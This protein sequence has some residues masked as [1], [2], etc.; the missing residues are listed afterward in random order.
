MRLVAHLVLIYLTT[1]ADFGV[2]NERLESPTLSVEFQPDTG[3]WALTDKRSGVRYPTVGFVATGSCAALDRP[4]V[5][6]ER[7]NANAVSVVHDEGVAVT[8]SLVRDGQS[9]ELRFE[10]NSLGEVRTLGDLLHMTKAD[11][12]SIVV[13]CREGLLI[14]VDEGNA[15]KRT[16]ASSD[17][18]GCHMNMIG[19]LK[20]GSAMLAT[21]DDA[22]T[23]PEVERS[24]D[25]SDSNSP[26]LTARFKLKRTARSIRLTPLGNG[27]WNTL[28]EGYRQI[29]EEKGMVVTLREKLRRNQG[30]ERM[31]GA[32]NVKLWHCLAR[33][34]NE[35]ST[36]EESVRVRWTF[37]ESAQIAEHIKKDLQIDRCLFIIG[38]FTEGGYDC[39]H[40]D[41]LPAN[42]ECGGNFALQ[43]AI[44]R[45]KRLGYVACLHDNYQDMYGNAKSFDLRYI[46]KDDAGKPKRG[47]R[48]L[49]GKP[50]LVCAPKQLELAMRPQNLPEIHRLF[51]PGNYFI[52]TTYAVGPRE[53]SDPNHPLDYNDDIRWKKKLSDHA[54][55]LFGLFGSEGGREWALPHSDWFEGLVGV[56]GRYFNDLKPRR[57][58]ARVIPFWEMVYHDCQIAYGKYGFRP[59]RAA[60]YV[61]HHALCARPLHYHSLPDHIYWKQNKRDSASN[62]E[63]SSL[64][65]E[66][67][68]TRT[69][70]GWAEGLHPVDAFLKNS[71]ELLGP[72]HEATAH[73]RLEHFEFLSPD[74]KLRRATYGSNE[75]KTTIV[76]NLGQEPANVTSHYGVDVLLPQ[77]GIVIDTPRFAAFYALRWNGQNYPGGALFT[78]RAADGE[79]LD[80]ASNVRVFH[81]FGPSR[82]KWHSRI[83]DVKKETTIHK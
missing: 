50:W 23:F 37:D 47:G 1:L 79:R 74:G 27:D 48:W 2:A 73:L 45:I 34:M 5:R 44:D 60:E 41:N 16:F 75:D 83:Y 76:V 64:S 11:E 26:S 38:G 82:I 65:A 67:T 43:D 12:G 52:D 71:Q 30:L 56:R 40:P 58:G 29:A 68:F 7:P 24:L 33:K 28:A 22:Y 72:L 3:R 4:F 81:A 61:V 14:P 20:A 80:M 13:P 25:E 32:A 35:D 62:T 51:N 77:W 21:W 54:R 66:A 46:E 57:L 15:F 19:I 17:Y 55:E 42:P 31:I 78:L 36:V 49:G 39:R 63:R 18:E 59:S 9:L 53:C 69:D 70:H 10:G 8:F 6:I